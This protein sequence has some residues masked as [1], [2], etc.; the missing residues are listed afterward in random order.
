[1][2]DD[3][4]KLCIDCGEPMV[5]RENKETGDQFWGCSAYPVCKH[6]ENIKEEDEEGWD[7]N[8]NY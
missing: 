2:I 7:K 5:I 8:S 4:E 3:D 6:S 1:M